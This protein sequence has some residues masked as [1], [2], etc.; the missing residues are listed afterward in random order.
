MRKIFAI[1]LTALLCFTMVACK[2][3]GGDSSSVDMPSTETN[4]V[5]ESNDWLLALGKSD[6]QIV[7]PTTNNI[8]EQQAAEEFNLFFSE[9]TGKTL[10]VI[11]DENLVF[12]KTDKYIS[13]GQ[14]A[15]FKTSGIKIDNEFL[16]YS[17]YIIKTVG[18]TVFVTG[19]NNQ[20]G[21]GTRN[22]I[23]ELLEHFVGYHFYAQDS[24]KLNKNVFNLKLLNFDI[25]NIPDFAKR[26]LGYGLLRSNPTY[27]KRLRVLNYGEDKEGVYNVGGHY[28]YDLMHKY[29]ND[30]TKSHWFASGSEQGYAYF[31]LCYSQEDMI[32][33]FAEDLKPFIINDVNDGR[34]IMLGITDNFAV[35]DCEAC[36]EGRR[37][38]YMNNGGEQVYFINYIAEY[39]TP[40][41]KENF[42]EKT[43][44]FSFFAY[45]MAE[46]P[47]VVYNETTG[48]YEPFSEYVIPRNDVGLYWAPINQDFA[49]PI[50]DEVGANSDARK[51]L[52]GWSMLFK[53]S[54]EG[55]QMWNYCENYNNYFINLPLVP[56]NT[57]S[58]NYKYYLE[59]G[60]YYM[61]EQ[62][63][64]A[65]YTSVPTLE[66]LKVYVQANL[67]WDTTLDV[68][69]L[70]RDFMSFYYGEASVAMSKY[71]FGLTDYCVELMAN[72]TG[73]FG[74]V[75]TAIDNKRF[76]PKGF[77][78][79]M[80]AWL[81]EAFAA[82]ETLKAT[83][84][85][86]YKALYGRVEKVYACVDYL[87]L[88]HY[89]SYYK[90]AERRAM[91][92]RFEKTVAKYNMYDYGEN[93]ALYDFINVWKASI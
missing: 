36:E 79:Q 71:L 55:I 37:T 1:F 27:A 73:F 10:P 2:G 5:E 3:N 93:K 59:H 72:D 75:G 6:Y 92:E 62:G 39:L 50:T 24:Y 63:P 25:V 44:R 77:V 56:L 60:V 67:L 74:G 17:G 42:P 83:D 41:L 88:M 15:L 85:D 14:N 40:W 20:Y 64:C 49:R 43:Y 19:S 4:K 76:W 52:D 68:N 9:A 26:C 21:E 23:Y 47:P 35:C 70:I 34:T 90:P 53:D 30:P 38:K 29:L 18:K 11:T 46:E 45:H 65:G 7:I 81:Q 89:T 12:S 82:V 80:D 78:D 86:R 51:V 8:I 54:N 48:E 22:G 13:L 31:A 57:V 33:Q 61:F 66:E 87:N 58:I 28:Q 16:S 84:M 32:I 91:L 69:E